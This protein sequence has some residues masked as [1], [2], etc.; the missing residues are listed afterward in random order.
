MNIVVLDGYTL[1]PGDLTWKDLEALGPCTVHDR[2]APEAVV[3]RAKD[4]EII[5]TNKT[6][7]SSDTIK[8]LPKLKYIGVL[9]TGYNIVDIEAARHKN[10]PV[11][12]VP[13][14][15]TQSVAQIVFAHLLNF[16]HHTA[17]H[18]QTVRSGRWTS[19]P[20]FCYWDTP[21]IELAGLTMGIIGFGRI[22]RATA[23]LSIAFG[24]N[25]IFYDIAKSSSIPEGCQPAG[26]DDIFRTS[27]VIS[28]HCPLTSETK[29]IINRERLEMMK[30][31]AFLINTSRGPL[32]DEQALADALNN[33]RIAGA[34]LDVLSE[35]PPGENNPLMK[36]RNCCITPHIAW[37][38]IAARK[39][40]LRV[41]VDNVASFLAGKP[42]NVV[43]GVK[44]KDVR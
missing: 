16:A 41:A 3:P 6:V 33:N 35:E 8:Q 13:T 17:H 9:A 21:L 4:A 1:N 37:A 34:G 42:Q 38:T 39:R 36:A 40:L 32:V 10:I 31:T 30:K 19:S 18:A 43:N 22:G 23:K 44:T 5:L 25:V 26:I 29:K 24:M 20:D 12:N 15:S 11:T 27:D 2:S 28:L 14:Y 7:L